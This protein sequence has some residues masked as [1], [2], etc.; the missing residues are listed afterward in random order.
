MKNTAVP[1]TLSIA[2][3]LF[4]S[5]ATVP[6]QAQNIAPTLDSSF[7]LA[8]GCNELAQSDGVNGV[9]VTSCDYPAATTFDG[10]SDFN[11]SGDVDSY[12]LGFCGSRDSN[13]DYF[14]FGTPILPIAGSSD[15]SWIV[16]GYNFIYHN[17]TFFDGSGGVQTYWYQILTNSLGDAFVLGQTASGTILA[18]FSGV[19]NSRTFATSISVPASVMARDKGGN[20][21]LAGSGQIT[22]YSPNAGQML[23]TKTI[24][25]AF[26]GSI[27]VD[28][29][30]DVY[31]AGTTNGGIPISFAPQP[32]PGG[33]TDSFL[34]V[35]S[36]KGD[37]IVYS[38]YIGGSGGDYAAGVKGGSGAS[39]MGTEQSYDWDGR[40]GECPGEYTNCSEAIFVSTFGPFRNSTLPTKLAFG[41]RV[42]GT[43]TIKKVT[44]KN[45]GDMPLH[46]T[47]VQTTGTEYAQ[48][49]TC[50]APVNPDKTCS[51]TVAF[52]PFSVG[53]HDETLTVTS[54]SLV[55]PQQI[56]LT[57][58]GK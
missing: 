55:S 41:K 1:L 28:K 42:V 38:T 37:R 45:T 40:Q 46:I 31:L 8:F 2:F 27:S 14:P 56:I 47:A 21:Y 4:F 7:M 44:F 26:I 6:A 9:G 11:W 10:A 36:P 18:K 57:G 24:P 49:N 23:Y 52:T 13:G 39:V 30:G 54:D 3:T 33:E 16:G 51:I 53:E 22:K 12:Y 5:L 50:S 20:I 25:G 58:A 29:Y 15:C 43:T 19:N 34:T 17:G 48:S 32:Q 35:L